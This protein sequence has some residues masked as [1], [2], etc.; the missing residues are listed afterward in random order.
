MTA[1]ELRQLR[2]DDGDKHGDEQA[3]S[4]RDDVRRRD[5]SGD[6]EVV[7]LAASVGDL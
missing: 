1:E 6:A 2:S 5:G 7:V 3:Q 4:Q